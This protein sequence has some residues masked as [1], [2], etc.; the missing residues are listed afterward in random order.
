MSKV[1]SMQHNSAVGGVSMNENTDPWHAH[2][3]C[4]HI[5]NAETL[6][7]FAE[8]EE[9]IRKIKAGEYVPRYNSYEE[10]VAEI[11]AEI[12]AEENGEEV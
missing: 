2:N 12:E 4:D 6:A 3:T 5:P 1:R 11:Y 10:M 8:T 9:I 7:A